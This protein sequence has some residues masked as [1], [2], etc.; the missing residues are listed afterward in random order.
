MGEVERG[1]DDIS[2]AEAASLLQWWSDSGVDCL[3]DETPRD[4]LRRAEPAANTAPAIVA[5]PRPAL[6]DQLDLFHAFLRTSEELP[7]AAPT[8]PRVCPAGDPASAAM[9]LTDMPTDGDCEAGVLITGEA[10]ALFDR[11][12]A[13]IGRSRDS[14]YL[15]GLSCLRSPTGKIAGKEREACAELARHHI[16]LVAPK[17]CLLLGDA[18]AKALIGMSPT[19]A[20]GKWHK[21]ST[22]SG[23]IDAMAS[24]HPS[25]LLNRP[26]DKKRA[27]A[28]LQQ[29]RDRIAQ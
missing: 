26:A 2:T 7:F 24:F 25:H 21:I 1:S 22:P 10:G 8:A 6:P 9:V 29:F 4:W 23:E 20:G 3:V 11:M 16:G 28:D 27:W 5:P 15:A 18:V 13:A 17:A 14:I 12:L 19:Q